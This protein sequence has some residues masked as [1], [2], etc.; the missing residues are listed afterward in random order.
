MNTRTFCN[1]FIG[2]ACLIVAINNQALAHTDGSHEHNKATHSPFVVLESSRTGPSLKYSNADGQLQTLYRIPK[3]ARLFQFDHASDKAEMLLSYGPS[4]TSKQGIWRFE[5]VLRPA[6]KATVRLTPI[7]TDAG[8][9]TWFFDPVYVPGTRNFYYISA[10]TAPN[11]TRASQDLQLWFYDNA[12]KRS[13]PVAKNATHPAVSEKG[14]LLLWQTKVQQ[15]Q[16]LTI[17]NQDSLNTST[18]DFEQSQPAIHFPKVSE[19]LQSVFFL[20]TEHPPVAAIPGFTMAYAHPGQQHKTWYAWRT[21]LTTSHVESATLMWQAENVRTVQLHPNGVKMGYISE[22]G[23]MLYDVNKG[24]TEQLLSGEN[25]WK[26]A[27]AAEN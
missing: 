4:G 1:F 6:Q 14:K 18:I 3:G 24:T 27:W 7:V 9:N 8:S 10:T 15:Q 21:A 19:N 17:L 22:A 5:Y 13:I 2:L 12:E 23:L 20:S 11:T 16:R 26:L 25:Y